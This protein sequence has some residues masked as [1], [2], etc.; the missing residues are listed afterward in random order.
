MS[1]PSGLAV[2]ISPTEPSPWKEIRPSSP[3][4]VAD[5]GAAQT[6]MIATARTRMKADL[7]VMV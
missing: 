2:K 4:K 5:A 3:G 1:L 7:V 6:A